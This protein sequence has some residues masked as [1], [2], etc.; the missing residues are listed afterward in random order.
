MTPAADLPGVLALTHDLN[1]ADHL[2]AS[3]VAISEQ[4]RQ[5]VLEGAMEAARADVAGR[6]TVVVDQL[7][8]LA[9]GAGVATGKIAWLVGQLELSAPGDS[10]RDEAREAVAGLQSSMQSMS[11][12]VQ[13]VADGGSVR[14]VGHS[15]EALRRGGLQLEELLT[16]LQHA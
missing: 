15:A 14:E 5:L 1:R 13:Q 9:V 12:A 10:R 8:R 7:C 11:Y 2:V 6:L 16:A 3:I 4:T